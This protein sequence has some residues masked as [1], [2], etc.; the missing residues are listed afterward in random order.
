MLNVADLRSLPAD[1][2]SAFIA[3]LTDRQA[4]ALK[5]DW[6]FWARPEQLEP[7]GDWTVWL[8]LAG[9]GWGK[10]RTGAEWVRQAKETNGRIAL[11]APTA[12]DARDVIV[13]GSSGIM[14]VSPP[15]DRP[16]YQSS[17][18][19]LTWQNGA[20]A[21]LYSA[22]EPDRLRG[23]EH[24]AAWCDEL[25]AWRYLQ[26]AWDMLM[27]GLR[28]GQQPRVCVTTTPRPLKLIRDLMR[29][30]STHVTRGSTYAN[31]ENL[32]PTF[33]EA[34]LA[35][36]EGTRLA[37]QE[38]QGDILDD[39]PGALWTY[40]MLDRQR[41]NAAPELDRIVVAIDP[42]A[43][44][45]DT[46]NE[47]GIV[48]V[49]TK[50]DGKEVR[51]YV[52]DDWSEGALSPEKWAKKAASLY[53]M[54]NADRIVIETNQGGEMALAVL[55]QVA[56]T[57]PLKSVHASRGKKTRAEPV[58]ALYEQ[59]RIFHAGHFRDLEDQMCSYTGESDQSSP[60]RMDALVWGFTD[61]M[62]GPQSGFRT[63]AT[64]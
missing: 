11:V 12:A 59:G 62:L 17:I 18:R 16:A 41:V 8:A 27:F 49:G 5:Y 23:P 15:W 7:V 44:S 14:S 10:T 63:I 34:I 53:H 46:A 24:S 60:D 50:R 55:R 25:A 2:G 58:S 36:Y 9:R 28:I 37:R 33:K 38:L 47:C 45:G 30:A 64:H 48:C 20:I 57:I 43:T 56:P 52:L 35:K 42:P 26:D 31:L 1:A 22:D 61:L 3:S 6:T 51:G 21:T 29:A 54:R 19:R 40:A 4:V 39:V 13:E 32:A